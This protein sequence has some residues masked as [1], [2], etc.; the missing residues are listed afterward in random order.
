MDIQSIILF[1]VSASAGVLGWFV[2]VLW[3]ADKQLRLDLQQL[4]RDL[5]RTYARRDEMKE[6]REALEHRF[7]R[8]EAKIDRLVETRP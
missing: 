5:P 1:G 2:R 7:D 6:M 8:I 4:E 3:E